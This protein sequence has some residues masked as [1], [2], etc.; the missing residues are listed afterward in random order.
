M[1]FITLLLLTVIVSTMHLKADDCQ[2][3]IDGDSLKTAPVYFFYTQ[4]YKKK[5]FDKAYPYWRTL[6]D[7]ASGFTE[8]TFYQGEEILQDK[9]EK[10]KDNPAMQSAYTDTLLEMYDKWIK[11][12]GKEDWVLGAKKAPAQIQYKND[13]AGAKQSLERSLQLSNKYPVVIQ[14]YFN[15]LNY[16]YQEKKIDEAAFTKKYEELI[17]ILDKNIAKR[18]Q[19]VS[20]YRE[21]KAAME[22]TFVGNFSDKSNPDDCAKLLEI[23]IK[24]YNTKPEDIATVE[25]V[26]DKT[27]G[28]A[29]SALNVELLE[30]LNRLKPNYS[31]AVRLANIYVKANKTDEAY[32]L[33][34]NAVKYETNPSNLSTLY[35]LLANM[36]AD[37]DSF[38]VARE[39]ALKALEQDSTNARAY[40]LIGYLYASS[41][42]LCGPGTGF[43]SQIVLWP[44]FDNFRKAVEH[45]DDEIKA[46]ANKMLDT[47]KQ[48]LPTKA[49]IAAKKLTVGAPY[50][51]KCWIEEETTVQVR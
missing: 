22:E 35:L 51:V 20:S 14:T 32:A 7:H 40:F 23:Y 16:E 26:Y 48:Y 41:G 33:Y 45:G 8:F 21:A 13:I 34:E 47:Y 10:A 39:L 36:K 44:A 5:D 43:Q 12:Y 11:C 1:K 28:C 25:N 3:H 30:K 15:L 2:R 38:P 31:Y 18:D 50:T 37:K 27:R 9:I 6:Y 17:A 19:Y 42:K 29:D 46:E 49:D 4:Y 24:Q